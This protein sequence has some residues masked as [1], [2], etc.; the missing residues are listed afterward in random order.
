MGQDNTL[1]DDQTCTGVYMRQMQAAY[2]AK[3]SINR[4]NR[5]A[6]GYAFA[7]IRAGMSD[8]DTAEHAVRFADAL[9]AELDK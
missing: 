8:R 5:I 7:F 2:E 4:R 6:E 1:N 9:I 3:K